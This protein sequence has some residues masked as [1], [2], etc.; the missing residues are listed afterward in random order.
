MKQRWGYGLCIL[1]M[2]VFAGCSEE[3][4]V[5][6]VQ[7]VEQEEQPSVSDAEDVVVYETLETEAGTFQVTSLGIFLVTPEGSKCVY[8]K[9]EGKEGFSGTSPQMHLYNDRLYFLTDI[10]YTEGNLDWLDCGIRWVDLETLQTGILD[11]GMDS[12]SLINNFYIDG[13]LIR[14]DTGG[15]SDRVFA[16]NE[17]VMPVYNGKSYGE[18]SEEEKTSYGLEISDYLRKNPG[19]LVEIS[20]YLGAENKAILDMDGDGATEEFVLRALGEEPHVYSPFDQYELWSGDEF[21]AGGYEYGMN[22]GLWAFSPNGSD[23]LLVLYSDGPSDDP[24]TWFYSY[25]DGRLQNAGTIYVNIHLAEI[26]ADGTVKGTYRH[27]VIQT[28]FIVAQWRMNEKKIMEQVQQESYDFTTLNEVQM[29]Q[30]LV[31][32]TEPGGVES[33]VLAPQTVKITKVAY[34]DDWVCLETADGQSGWLKVIDYMTVEEN[35][36]I[37]DVFDYNTLFFAG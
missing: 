16:L 9:T 33:F 10:A 19:T 25:A 1:A 15:L 26:S 29:L 13:G 12:L 31:L 18:L 35:K 27:D 34:G 22:N 20:N 7:S 32:Y 8:D 30:E 4:P 6:P 11:L 14:L 28:D 5:E 37:Q 36:N 24:T 17:S 21:V 2:M 23:I 3:E